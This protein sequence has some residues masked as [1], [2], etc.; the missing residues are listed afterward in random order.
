[1][2]QPLLDA[3][4]HGKFKAKCQTHGTEKK[5]LMTKRLRIGVDVEYVF[6]KQNVNFSYATPTTD[7]LEV[8]EM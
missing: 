4:S 3:G 5:N 2:A 8:T 1:M 7:L 6:N